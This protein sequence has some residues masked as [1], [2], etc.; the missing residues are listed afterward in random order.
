MKQLAVPSIASRLFVTL[1]SGSLCTLMLDPF[2]SALE[3]LKA[4]LRPTPPAFD[5]CDLEL[6]K[7]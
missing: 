6:E 2:G 4:Q 3:W 5:T 7:T 1:R